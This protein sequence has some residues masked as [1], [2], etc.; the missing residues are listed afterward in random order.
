MGTMQIFEWV[1]MLAQ[2]DGAMTIMYSIYH[3]GF[4][5]SRHGMAAAQSVVLLVAT[6]LIAFAQKRLQTWQSM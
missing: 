5:Y 1:Y 2:H 4:L 6:M 3:E